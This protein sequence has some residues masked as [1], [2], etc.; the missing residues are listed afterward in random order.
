MLIQ[1][2]T[3]PDPNTLEETDITQLT[4]IMLKTLTEPKNQHQKEQTKNKTISKT[5]HKCPTC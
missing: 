3:P 1:N 2:N 4:D 5:T